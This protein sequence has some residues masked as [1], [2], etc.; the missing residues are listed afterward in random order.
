MELRSLEDLLIHELSDLYDAENQIVQALPKMASAAQSPELR[1]AFEQHLAETKAQVERLE[2]VF[3]TLGQPAKGETC[4]G[5][6][7]LVREG[8]KSIAEDAEPAV[9]DAALIGSAQRIEHYEMA[10]YGT[11]KT[12]ARMLGHQEAAQLLQQ[13]LTEEEATDKKLSNLAEQSINVR[14]M[15]NR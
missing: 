12:Y 11:A 10:G 8:Q 7:G 2:K 1:A 3:E 6:K 15:Q 5:M 9:K 14:A 4:E 13:T